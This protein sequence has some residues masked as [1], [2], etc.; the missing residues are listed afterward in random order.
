MALTG[1]QRNAL[2]NKRPTGRQSA[3]QGIKK[4]YPPWLSVF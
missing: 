3:I 2:R 4:E 1:F